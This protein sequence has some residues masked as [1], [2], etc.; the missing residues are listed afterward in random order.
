MIKII[1]V[2]ILLFFMATMTYANEKDYCAYLKYAEEYVIQHGKIYGKV[3]RKIGENLN[4]N[5]GLNRAVVY[6]EKSK[7]QLIKFREE[8]L[9]RTSDLVDEELNEMHKILMSSVD[10]QMEVVNRSLEYLSG[11]DPS[12][13]SGNEHASFFQNAADQD[14]L[15]SRRL[16][17]VVEDFVVKY[18]DVC[19]SSRNN[20]IP[21]PVI[22]MGILAFV[23]YWVMKK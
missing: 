22:M 3:Q 20:V 14:D 21:Y 23:L 1:S 7:R 16:E 15:Y 10:L 2:S 17:N 8:F 6:L 4:N 19:S 11:T 9:R 5:V 12:T 13:A 18:P